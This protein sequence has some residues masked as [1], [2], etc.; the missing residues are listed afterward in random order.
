MTRDEIKQAFINS[1]PVILDSIRNEKPIRCE[2][3]QGFGWARDEKQNIVFQ[4]TLRSGNSVIITGA[5][6]VKECDK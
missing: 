5:E 1:T 3:I 2:Y 6:T 4:V